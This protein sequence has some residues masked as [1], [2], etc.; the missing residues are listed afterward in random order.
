M[1]SLSQIEFEVE[2]YKNIIMNEKQKLEKYKV[3]LFIKYK[4]LL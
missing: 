2:N 1:I 3:M 4:N